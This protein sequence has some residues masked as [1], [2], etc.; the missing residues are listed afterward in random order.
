MPGK[1]HEPSP[2][3]GLH[4]ADLAPCGVN[5]RC[6]AQFCSSGGAGR[7]PAAFRRDPGAAAAAEP[8]LPAE[9]G[10]F[11]A[12]LDSESLSAGGAGVHVRTLHRSTGAFAAGPRLPGQLGERQH[13]TCEP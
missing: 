11:L 13:R 12:G 4:S 2:Q 3:S 5:W 8:G 10:V 7:V 1:F 9:N 6:S